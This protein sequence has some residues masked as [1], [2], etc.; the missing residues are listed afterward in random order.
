MS[1]T[2]K[3]FGIRGPV[4]A[5]GGVSVFMYVMHTKKAQVPID[6][7]MLYRQQQQQQDLA[8]NEEDKSTVTVCVHV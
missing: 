2:L 8:K 6:T 7:R 4:G 1:K 5:D 3:D